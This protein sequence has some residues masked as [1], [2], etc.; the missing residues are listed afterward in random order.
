MY[1]DDGERKNET[2]HAAQAF[3][4]LRAREFCCH[5]DGFLAFLRLAQRNI[6]S[7]SQSG[8]EFY[9]HNPDEKEKTD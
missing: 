3:P 5:F 9:F 4:L 7:D 1:R 2:R 8:K 6:C